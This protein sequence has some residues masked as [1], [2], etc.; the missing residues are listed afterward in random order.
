MRSISRYVFAATSLAA[1]LSLCLP[2]Q[3]QWY[4][5]EEAPAG[6]AEILSP[7]TFKSFNIATGGQLASWIAP[8]NDVLGLTF[9]LRGGY[10]FDA[11]PIYI[12]LE[13]P[14]S[15][16]IPDAGDEEFVLGSIGLNFKSRIDPDNPRANVFTGWSFD[17]YIPT[18]MGSV[19]ARTNAPSIGHETGLY[20]T[21]MPGIHVSPEAI[22]TVG[23]FDLVLPGHLLFFQFELS[24]ATYFPVTDIDSRSI[25]GAL[26][27]GAALGVHI[28]EPIAF[29]LEGKG[30]SPLGAEDEN[31]TPLP[32]QFAL[33]PGFRMKFGPFHP[34]VWVAL[35]LNREYREAWSDIIIGVDLAIWL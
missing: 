20:N 10:A 16:G 22:T 26:A 8:G 34:A 33:S 21:L 23:T 11:V 5:D 19:D 13:L 27:W 32:T 4:D 1:I 7:F 18:F 12:G 28:A 3:A 9:L 17:I 15:A 25:E 2:A 30:Y 35:P 14:L 29:L 24:A 31:G 6:S